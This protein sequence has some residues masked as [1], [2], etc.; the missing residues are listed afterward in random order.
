MPI[1]AGFEKLASVAEEEIT[2]T[3]IGRQVHIRQTRRRWS[4][5]E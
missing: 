5:G 4:I 2:A 1:I 3:R